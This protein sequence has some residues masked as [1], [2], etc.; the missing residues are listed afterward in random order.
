MGVAGQKGRETLS[1]YYKLCW[2]FDFKQKVRYPQPT[3]KFK[4][5]MS[6]WPLTILRAKVKQWIEAVQHLYGPIG[7]ARLRAYAIHS[8][9][10]VHPDFPRQIAHFC[11]QTLSTTSNPVQF[12]I[13]PTTSNPVQII[14]HCPQLQILS[15]LDWSPSLLK[16]RIVDDNNDTNQQTNYGLVIF[17]SG[18]HGL[19]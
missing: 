5:K 17:I 14:D 13:L 18:P 11:P 15:K 19:S 4:R 10:K 9:L 6:K 7:R 16:D 3:L 2:I 8:I 1:L 12:R